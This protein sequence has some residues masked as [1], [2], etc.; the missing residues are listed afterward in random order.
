MLYLLLSV[1][2]VALQADDDGSSTSQCLVHVETSPAAR[3]LSSL[4]LPILCSAHQQATRDDIFRLEKK[5]MKA[6]SCPLI[7]R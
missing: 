7:V 1:D 5:R 6:E 3:L 2:S 4:T